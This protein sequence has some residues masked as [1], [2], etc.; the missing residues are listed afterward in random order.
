MRIVVRK[1]NI[2]QSNTPC[3]AFLGRRYVL[4]VQQV[5]TTYRDCRGRGVDT[6]P[7][8]ES[9]PWWHPWLGVG[10]FAEEIAAVGY[11]L[12]RNDKGAR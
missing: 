4:R 5:V 11:R 2:C 10:R 3:F 6:R 7:R 8:S 1:G 9:P 12:S